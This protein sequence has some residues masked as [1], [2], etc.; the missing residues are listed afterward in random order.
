MFLNRTSVS[1]LMT[2]GISR[3][4]PLFNFERVDELC[5]RV[6]DLCEKLGSFDFHES[7]RFS[8]SSDVKYYGPDLDIRVKNY[9]HLYFSRACFVHFER[10]DML[11]A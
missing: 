5:P 9:H 2:I 3:E 10:L 11:C 7:F 6:G 4:L 1:K 8:I